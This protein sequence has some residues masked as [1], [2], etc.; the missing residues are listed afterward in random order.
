MNHEDVLQLVGF[1]KDNRQTVCSLEQH[2]SNVNNGLQ[3][4]MPG[5]SA[6][7]LNVIININHITQ[8]A[9]VSWLEMS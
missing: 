4:K 6:S 7:R 1:K 9:C 2:A 8:W 3:Y 5:E